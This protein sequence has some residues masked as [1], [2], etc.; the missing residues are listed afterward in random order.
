MADE[1]LRIGDRDPQY[2]PFT[3]G[4]SMSSWHE[5]WCCRPIRQLRQHFVCSRAPGHSGLHVASNPHEGIV[6]IGNTT[7][8]DQRLPEGF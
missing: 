5:I 3:F 6:A 2:V 1:T 8:I 7:P 4:S